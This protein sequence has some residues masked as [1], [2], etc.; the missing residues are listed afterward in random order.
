MVSTILRFVMFLLFCGWMLQGMRV[1]CS[2]RWLLL[3]S[4]DDIDWSICWHNHWLV[5]VLQPLI[6]MEIRCINQRSAGLL[7]TRV[8]RILPDG[9]ILNF[10]WMFMTHGSHL[11]FCIPMSWIHEVM[12][13]AHDVNWFRIEGIMTAEVNLKSL[14]LRS[15]HFRLNWMQSCM[16]NLHYKLDLHLCQLDKWHPRVLGFE[17]FWHKTGAQNSCHTC[18]CL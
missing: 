11:V 18:L 17:V 1:V 2:N 16:T 10:E 3:S 9:E 8:A 15:L 12:K 4:S 13:I 14:C 7:V 5:R 6:W